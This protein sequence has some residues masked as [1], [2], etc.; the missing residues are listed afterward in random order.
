MLVALQ[1]TFALG[2]LGRVERYL[3]QYW[4]VLVAAKIGIPP[5]WSLFEPAFTLTLGLPYLRDPLL[6][7]SFVWFLDSG[8]RNRSVPP[9]KG[10]ISWTS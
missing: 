3:K 4:A 2:R 8:S 9:L 7:Y 6:S 5:R 1:F 10:V